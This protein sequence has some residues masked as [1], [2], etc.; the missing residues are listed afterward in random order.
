MGFIQK[1]FDFIIHPTHSRTAIIVL[2]LLAAVPLTVFLSQQQQ[3]IKQKAAGEDCSTQ[4][5]NAMKPCTDTSNQCRSNCDLLSRETFPDPDVWQANFDACLSICSDNK[6]V[7]EQD[8][9]LSFTCVNTP[10][11]PAPTVSISIPIIDSSSCKNTCDAN[12]N[13]VGTAENLIS[14]YV[15]CGITA[16]TLTPVPPTLAPSLTAAQT[17]SSCGEITQPGNYV[18][19]RDLKADYSCLSIHDVSNV[20]IDCNGHSIDIVGEK[21]GTWAEI[22]NVKGFSL[23]SC[24][25]NTSS[26]FT[27]L[28]IAS[29]IEGVINGNSIN[30]SIVS[31]VN[32]VN[33]KFSNNEV[34]GAYSQ[35]HS[36]NVIIENN[37]FVGNPEKVTGSAVVHLEIGNNNKV[38]NNR[39]DGKSDGVYYIDPYKNVGYDDGI[40]LTGESGD[41]IQ[42]NEIKNVWD[43]GIETLNKVFDTKITSNIIENAAICGIGGWYFNS[44]KGNTISHNTIRNSGSMFTIFRE[45]GLRKESEYGPQEQFVYFKDNSF[46]DN[47]FINPKTGAVSATIDLSYNEKFLSSTNDFL[48]FKPEDI[49]TGNNIFKDNDFNTLNLYLKPANMFVD[50]GGNRCNSTGESDL[51]LKCTQNNNV[52]P[53]IASSGQLSTKC[54]LKGK[55]DANCDNFINIV[56]FQIWS[57]DFV[58]AQKGVINEQSNFDNLNGITIVDFNIWKKSFGDISLPH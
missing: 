12:W 17:L 51:P 11:D 18:L 6:S 2:L 45:H 16:S 21:G 55:G 35:I 53:S 41:V 9:A 20:S 52:L 56:D 40:I 31:V 10:V 28:R 42:D 33:L 34:F 1:F 7:C 14:C 3:N 25:L 49:I 37:V 46:I 30:K 29:I 43:C 39:I 15:S 5:Q 54:H 38:L 22:T 57:T 44:W 48:P 47:K 36:D 24:T 58:N 23:T 8:I 26:S 50:G 27:A 19:D 4:L 32:S 13:G